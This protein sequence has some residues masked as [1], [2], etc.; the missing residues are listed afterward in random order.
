[1]PYPI[2]P[3]G[4]KP[5]V[6]PEA[7]LPTLWYHKTTLSAAE[8]MHDGSTPWT[9]PR[10][11]CVGS[12]EDGDRKKGGLDGK[13]WVIR[14]TLKHRTGCK[15]ESKPPAL[16]D[17]M[18]EGEHWLE[19]RDATALQIDVSYPITNV[20]EIYQRSPELRNAP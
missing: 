18:R 2:Q 6:D 4:T 5:Q 10:P 16:R 8:A 11:F 13:V 17:D 12:F 19:V 9:K 15:H 1:M 14:F 20:Q 7:E 3:H